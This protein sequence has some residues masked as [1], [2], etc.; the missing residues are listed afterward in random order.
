MG[1]DKTL[2]EAQKGATFGKK[3]CE[4]NEQKS[5]EE[6]KEK[7]KEDGEYQDPSEIDAGIGA[8]KIP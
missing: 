6:G 4:F 5:S 1:Q 8:E 3:Q 7:K 2:E